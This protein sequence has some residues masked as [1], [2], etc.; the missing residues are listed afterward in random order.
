[1]VNKTK[2]VIDSIFLNHNRAI[3][4]FEFSKENSLVLEDTIYHFDL[5][6]VN[7]EEELYNFGIETYIYNDKYV[8]V[9]WPELLKP[10]L[11]EN[12]TILKFETT[13]NNSRL[14]NLI[15]TK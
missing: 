2:D 6:R 15:N 12:V 14:I 13:N 11:Q 3:S 8:L 4:T 10:M 1:M 7:D 5:Y 9:E